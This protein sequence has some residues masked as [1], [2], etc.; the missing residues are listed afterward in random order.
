MS[1]V[2]DAPEVARDAVRATVERSAALSSAST[3]MNVL[4]TVIACYGLL[5]NS[6][7]VVIG[8]MI[9]AMLLNPIL[10]F[11]MGLAE[12]APRLLKKSAI[13][14]AGGFLAV[15]ATALVIGLVHENV[16]LTDEILQRTTPRFFDLMIA[17]AGGAAG[18]YATASPRLSVAFVGVAVA[19]ALVP[20]LS[21]SALL[22][23][24]GDLRRALG[25]LLLTTVNIVA[26]QLASSCV[27]W[28]AGFRGATGSSRNV[29]SFIVRGA[30]SLLVVVGL[31][32]VFIASMRT[33]VAKALFETK[34]Q[35]VI[36]QAVSV[37]PD[38][39]LLAV[40][41]DDT[42]PGTVVV[43]AVTRAPSPPTAAQVSAMKSRL[44]LTGEGRTVELRVRNVETTIV[45]CNGVLHGNDSD[46]DE[47]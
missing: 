43:R 44:P 39:H 37:W 16:P 47:P 6:P 34:V 32:T 7:A 45:T 21:A 35:G 20:P 17:L 11:S 5:S 36:K 33:V 24:R 46:P 4:A 10:G 13:G 22:L 14:L 18:A 3:A 12:S 23:A 19:T 41:F 28:L 27:F 30:P 15:F 40:R 26:I 9:V 38:A 25:A 1:D 8:A 2:S 31:A 42:K 29:R